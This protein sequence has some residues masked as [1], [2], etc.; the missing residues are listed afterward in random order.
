MNRGAWWVTVHGVEESNTTK[1]NKWD[2]IKLKS[3][4]AAKETIN[5]T[6]K[7]PIDWEKIFA[8]DATDKGL[9]LY[10]CVFKIYK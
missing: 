3:L 7:Q 1:R 4:Y 10:L 5:R 6:K 8:N 2:L 9:I